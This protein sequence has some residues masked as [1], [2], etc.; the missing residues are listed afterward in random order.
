M[1]SGDLPRR[2]SNNVIPTRKSRLQEQDYIIGDGRKPLWIKSRYIFGDA[3]LE[4]YDSRRYFAFSG[5][6]YQNYS[7]LIEVDLER[8]WAG[9]DLNR[10]PRDF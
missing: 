10:R 5:N 4:I 2:K 6:G 3:G 1:K 8:V 9:P 7:T